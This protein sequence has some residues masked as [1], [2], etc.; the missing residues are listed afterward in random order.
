MTLFKTIVF[1][2]IQSYQNNLHDSCLFSAQ[3]LKFMKRV[4]IN[5]QIDL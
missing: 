3:I 2:K 1:G 5:F 4:E